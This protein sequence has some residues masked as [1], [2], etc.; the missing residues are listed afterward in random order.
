MA[1]LSGADETSAFPGGFEDATVA[2]EQSADVWDPIIFPELIPVAL[3]SL[4]PALS[5]WI[6]TALR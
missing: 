2:T 1:H 6:N 4:L 3:H 5:I